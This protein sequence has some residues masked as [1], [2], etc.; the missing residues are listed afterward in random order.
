[1]DSAS[2]G[3][4]HGLSPNPALGLE[5]CQM[6]VRVSRSSSLRKDYRF[7]STESKKAMDPTD[8]PSASQLTAR[9]AGYKEWLHKLKETCTRAG[10]CLIFDEAGQQCWEC[11]LQ[12][13]VLGYPSLHP[14]E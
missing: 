1:M 2:Q 7:N 12:E 11:A 9:A 5:C 10:V 6:P 14:F 3:L 8:P 4:L 13:L